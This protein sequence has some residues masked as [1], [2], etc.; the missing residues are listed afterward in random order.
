MADRDDVISLL[1]QMQEEARVNNTLILTRFA[2]IESAT[3]RE[4]KEIKNVLASHERRLAA[5]ER[6]P[7]TPIT[8]ITRSELAEVRRAQ[9]D[10][11][12]KSKADLE[13][14]TLHIQRVQRNLFTMA[15]EIKRDPW[16][17]LT[18][19]VVI[20]GTGALVWTERV[21]WVAGTL[22]LGAYILPSVFGKKKAKPSLPSLGGQD[23]RDR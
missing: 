22:F 5:L 4:A 14:A 21:T 23:E 18:A 20:L 11:D 2:E 8:P 7:P 10:H 15:L 12:L 19:L 17:I 3:S 9:S 13:A 6:R 1:L 16:V